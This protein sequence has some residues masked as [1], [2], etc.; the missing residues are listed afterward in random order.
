MW[1][2][3]VNFIVLGG[4]INQKCDAGKLCVRKDILKAG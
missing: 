4:D 2:Q 1:I 3:I